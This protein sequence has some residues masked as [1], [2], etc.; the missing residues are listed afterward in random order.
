MMRP[1]LDRARFFPN[2]GAELLHGADTDASPLHVLGL[3]RR[4]K[5]LQDP[6]VSLSRR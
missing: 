1:E 5:P 6:R 3:H 2:A 4:S